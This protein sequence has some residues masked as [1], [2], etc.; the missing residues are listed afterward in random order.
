[1]CP[2]LNQECERKVIYTSSAHWYRCA[3][4]ANNDCIGRVFGCL[5]NR[6][7]SCGTLDIC[8]QLESVP[9]VVARL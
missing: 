6:T 4:L 3:A 8:I 9:L 7:A 5:A 2:N 1:M